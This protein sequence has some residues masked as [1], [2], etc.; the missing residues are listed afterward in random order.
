MRQPLDYPAARKRTSPGRRIGTLVMIGLVLCV[1][2]FVASFVIIVV[3][4]GGG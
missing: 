1:I 3:Y 2:A 4:V